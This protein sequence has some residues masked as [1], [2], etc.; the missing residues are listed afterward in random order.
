MPRLLPRSCITVLLL[1]SSFFFFFNDTATTEIYTLS[2]HD[3]L[4]ISGVSDGRRIRCAS[5]PEPAS[6]RVDSVA[7]A[8]TATPAKERHS[9]RL[10]DALMRGGS[11]S[12]REGHG[13][14]GRVQQVVGESGGLL[15]PPG[16]E[17]ERL[18]RVHVAQTAERLEHAHPARDHHVVDQERPPAETEAVVDAD[19]LPDVRLKEQALEDRGVMEAQV[20]HVQDRLELR[21]ELDVGAHVEQEEA[22]IDEV[23]LALDL[24]AAEAGDEAVAAHQLEPGAGERQPLAHP[25]AEAAAGEIRIVE[26]RVAPPR[27]AVGGVAV[28]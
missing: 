20:V 25:V 28:A 10:D 17:R 2:L 11:C 9:L 14:K 13:E 27:D 18:V 3:A 24:A 1:L 16:R 8:T 6:A 22:G 26:D 12:E 5:S 15:E 23:G 4:P 7:A 19:V 21:R